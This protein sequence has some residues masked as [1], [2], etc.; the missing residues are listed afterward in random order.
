MD[1]YSSKTKQSEKAIQR[2]R[3]SPAPKQSCFESPFQF[4]DNRIS[5][6]VQRRII[7]NIR[8]Q[9]VISN[10]GVHTNL[11][12]NVAQGMFSPPLTRSGNKPFSSSTFDPMGRTRGS[13]AQASS[14]RPVIPLITNPKYWCAGRARPKFDSGVVSSI[15]ESAKTSIDSNGVQLYS[16]RTRSGYESLPRKVDSDVYPRRYTSYASIGHIKQWKDIIAFSI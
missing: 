1:N 6:S 16:C 14:S 2:V 8:C 5:T 7:N 12:Q 15:Y 13:Q 9:D 10:N 3:I 4:D 11:F